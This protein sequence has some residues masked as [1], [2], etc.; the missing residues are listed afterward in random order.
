MVEDSYVKVILTWNPIDKL[1]AFPPQFQIVQHPYMVN[2]S[3]TPE[4]NIGSFNQTLDY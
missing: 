3:T 2:K 4:T 1:P